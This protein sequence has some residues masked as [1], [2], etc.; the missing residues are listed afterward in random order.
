[1]VVYGIVNMYRLT[2]EYIRLYVVFSPLQFAIELH[3]LKYNSTEV[4]FLFSLDLWETQGPLNVPE[5][6][7]VLF[8]SKCL[9][10]RKL[11]T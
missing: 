5:H 11:F 8:L 2:Y 1:M 10:L 9:C 4:I 6:A 3:V 7:A